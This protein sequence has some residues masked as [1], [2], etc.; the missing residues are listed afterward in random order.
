MKK[1]IKMIIKEFINDFKTNI[2]EL[3]NKKTFYRQIPNLLTSIRAFVPIPFNILYFT[4][5][6]EG[7]VI[8]LSIAFFTDAIDGKIARKYGLVSKFGATLDAVC[9]KLMVIGVIIPVCTNNY[10]LII[11]LILEIIIASTNTIA[12]IMG[13]NTK[14]SKI[15]KFKTWPLFI[16]IILAYVALFVKLPSIILTCLITITA[17]LQVFTTLDYLSK[18]FLLRQQKIKKN[19]I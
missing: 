11:N 1:R 9:D 2:K 3:F 12:T 4:G 6:L 5:N 15:G 19:E 7:A 17:S 14:S 18:N 8:I 16:T 10:G 13:I